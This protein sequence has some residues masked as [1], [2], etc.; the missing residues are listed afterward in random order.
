MQK[1]KIN[2]TKLW[3]NGNKPADGSYIFQINCAECK[4]GH[5]LMSSSLLLN[6]VSLTVDETYKPKETVIT[7]N[8]VHAAEMQHHEKLKNFNVCSDASTVYKL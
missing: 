5:H 3:Q 2:I 8:T 4:S 6:Q 7:R 1:L